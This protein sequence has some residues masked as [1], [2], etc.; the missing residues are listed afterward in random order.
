[1]GVEEKRLLTGLR[2]NVLSDNQLGQTSSW[3]ARLARIRAKTALK[4]P[5][6]VVLAAALAINGQVATFDNSLAAAAAAHD[7]LLYLN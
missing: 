5:D 3:P 6:A 1:M 2:L 7:V 4:M